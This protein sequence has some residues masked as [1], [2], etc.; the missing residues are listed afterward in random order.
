MELPIFE[1]KHHIHTQHIPHQLS[2]HAAAAKSVLKHHDPY[3]IHMIWFLND[4]KRLSPWY[5]EKN[6]HILNCSVVWEEHTMFDSNYE[7]R[8]MY[9]IFISIENKNDPCLCTNEISTWKMF[10]QHILFKLPSLYHVH[11]TL[12]E[13]YSMLSPLFLCWY[14]YE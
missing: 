4:W 6:Q 14:G 1:V 7:N 8:L 12:I 2:P 9:L 3:L 5:K 13:V 11:Y 10:Y